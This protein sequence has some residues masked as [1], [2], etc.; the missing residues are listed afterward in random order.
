MIG[1]FSFIL[2]LFLLVLG[3]LGFIPAAISAG[4]PTLLTVDPDVVIRYGDLFGIFPVNHLISGIQAVLGLMGMVAAIA[5]DSARAYARLIAVSYL[6]LGAMG[7]LPYAQTFFGLT[8]LFGAN[9]FLHLTLGT[10]A[11]YFSGVNPGL[12]KMASR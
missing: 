12:L 6:I 7:L 8:P 5:P 11:L 1:R 9:V 3:A 2:G 4:H 10:I